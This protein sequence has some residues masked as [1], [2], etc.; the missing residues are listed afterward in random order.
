MGKTWV[1]KLHPQN[2][3]KHTCTH[4]LTHTTTVD[5]HGA[6]Q[7]MSTQKTTQKQSYAAGTGNPGFDVYL[8]THAYTHTNTHSAYH[9]NVVLYINLY[10]YVRLYTHAC[11]H[12]NRDTQT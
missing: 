1:V 7:S 9:T 8:H 2:T 3:H 10:I 12:T 5:P 4:T 11:T 6:V